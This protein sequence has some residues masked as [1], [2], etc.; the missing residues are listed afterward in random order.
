MIP[1]RPEKV[2]GI[3]HAIRGYDFESTH[4]GFAGTDLYDE[5]L[6]DRVLESA[7]IQIKAVGGDDSVLE[8]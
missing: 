5:N 7:R 4:G 1:L 6:K 3:W 8:E 2:A